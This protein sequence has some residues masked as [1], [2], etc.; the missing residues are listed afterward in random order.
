MEIPIS[1]VDPQPLLHGLKDEF[2]SKPFNPK[3]LSQSVS[4]FDKPHDIRCKLKQLRELNQRQILLSMTRPLHIQSN[5]MMATNAIRTA[6]YNI[7]TF[8][9]LN[10]MSQ[11]SKIAN[12]YFLINAFLSTIK[13]I[14]ITAGKPVILVPLMCVIF[15]SMVKDAY[16]DWQRH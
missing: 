2:S 12:L 9:P 6:K 5:H 7:I 15:F 8:I 16:E 14:S 10:L 1:S 11:F 4:I 13:P 3:K